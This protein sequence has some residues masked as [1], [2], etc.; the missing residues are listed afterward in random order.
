RGFGFIG[1]GSTDTLFRFL[2]ASVFR[3]TSNSGFPE[4][5]PDQTR[6]DVEQFLLAFDSDLAPVV[7]QHVTLTANNA[8]SV[9]PRI[10]MLI[11]RAS[12]PL[13]AKSLGGTVMECDL[14]ARV[15]KNGRT[16]TL[17][18]D[19]AAANFVPD[20]GSNPISDAELRALAAN[21]GQEVTYTAATP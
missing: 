14:V 10:D 17:L 21:A 9:A 1:D 20:N 6:R 7:G 4:K 12:A 5:D 16:M 18:Y 19:S 13:V 11:Q 2:T 8:Q 3:P 15:V